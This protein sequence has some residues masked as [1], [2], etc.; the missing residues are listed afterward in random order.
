MAVIYGEGQLF[1]DIRKKSFCEQ[2]NALDKK[3]RQKVLEEYADWK[4]LSDEEKQYFLN[5]EIKVKTESLLNEDDILDEPTTMLEISIRPKTAEDEYYESDRYF[6]DNKLTDEELEELRIEYEKAIE[7]Y[8]RKEAET[9]Q[10]LMT[11]K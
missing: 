3:G 5:S 6:E 1:F 11:N 8:E 10:M 4:D 7:E 2:L 9:R